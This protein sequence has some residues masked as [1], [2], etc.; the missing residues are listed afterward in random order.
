M[1]AGKKEQRTSPSGKETFANEEDDDDKLTPAEL[2]ADQR[3]VT[4]YRRCHAAAYL[5]L[6]GGVITLIGLTSFLVHVH[7]Q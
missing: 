1:Q 6:M 3:D 2:E 4:M 7:R 5:F